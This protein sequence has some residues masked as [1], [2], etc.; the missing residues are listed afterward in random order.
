MNQDEQILN[1]PLVDIYADPKFNCR[2]TISP[3]NVHDLVNSIREFGLLQ[4]IVVRPAS[5]TDLKMPPEKKWHLAAGFRRYMAH[6][7]GE[8]G[9]IRALV[10]HVS[11]IDA[12][13]LN[14]NENIQREE[15]NIIQEA[16]AVKALRD[17]GLDT[18]E[19][20]SKLGQSFG[21][22]QIR[23]MLIK[24]P[25]SIQ[26]AARDGAIIQNDIRDLYSHHIAGVKEPELV[27]MV[28][29]LITDRDM[30][31]KVNLKPP[32]KNPLKKFKR[33]EAELFV[34]R[35][36]LRESIGNGLHTRIIAWATGFASDDE[37]FEDIENYVKQNNLL[38]D[39]ID[40]CRCEIAH[41]GSQVPCPEG[42]E[43][44]LRKVYTRNIVTIMEAKK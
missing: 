25:D 1:I 33:K 10:S 39:Y 38:L 44:P 29:G 36:H 5:E 2:G 20:R 27:E 7:V 37:I 16:K 15:L 14:L 43:I 19:I 21:W 8:F 32:N 24:L 3:S 17:A 18:T 11:D 40:N 6:C 31:H 41:I 9:T 12:R 4:P 35:D 23:T 42:L 22:V 34:L 30:G 28:R 13:V 26:E